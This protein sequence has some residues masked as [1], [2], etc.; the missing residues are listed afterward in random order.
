MSINTNILQ[1]LVPN[2][3]AF[4]L[5]FYW[6]SKNFENFCQLINDKFNKKNIT[7][8][9]NVLSKI[10]YRSHQKTNQVKLRI[11]SAQ[12]NSK[13]SLVFF[14]ILKVIIWASLEIN[15]HNYW[16]PMQYHELRQLIENLLVLQKTAFHTLVV[17]WNFEQQSKK[18]ISTNFFSLGTVFEIRMLFAW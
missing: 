10:V 8:H 9:E 2:K 14:L 17:Y 7:H 3:V 15:V 18:I 1:K 11:T 5:F 6:V 13:N 12:L 16:L 4:S